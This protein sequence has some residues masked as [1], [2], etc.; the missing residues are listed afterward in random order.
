MEHPTAWKTERYSQLAR[1]A[2]PNRRDR[3]IRT[4]D[5]IIRQLV[6]HDVRLRS[7]QYGRAYLSELLE[8]RLVLG[9]LE[10]WA[11]VQFPN[12]GLE[13]SD[14][15]HLDGKMGSGDGTIPSRIWRS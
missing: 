13:A 7:S 12:C 9:T 5:E 4:H 1:R 3:T 10:R 11:Q 2:T 8:Q 6:P 14:A 15:M